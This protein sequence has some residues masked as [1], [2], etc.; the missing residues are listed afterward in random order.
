VYVISF[1]INEISTIP[2]YRDIICG[3][4][5]GLFISWNKYEELY[6]SF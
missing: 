2:N 6:P 3:I 5:K 1:F 4:E